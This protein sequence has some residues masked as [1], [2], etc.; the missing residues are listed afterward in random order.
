LRIYLLLLGLVLPLT[1]SAQ[2]D[3]GII[4]YGQEEAPRPARSQ[5][6]QK[7]KTQQKRSEPPPSIEAEAPERSAE[8]ELEEYGETPPHRSQDPGQE[9]S[10]AVGLQ[11]RGQ[12]EP[13][14]LARGDDPN[15]GLGIAA[16]GGVMLLDGARGHGVDPLLSGGVR[17]TWEFGRLTADE[18]LSEALFADVSWQYSTLRQGTLELSG[19]THYHHLT[20]A[21]AYAFALLPAGKLGAFLQLGGGVAYQLSSLRIGEAETVLGGMKPLLRY[22][23][24]FRGAVRLAEASA[25]RLEYRLELTRFRRG[26]MDDTFIGLSSGAVF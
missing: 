11:R 18:S 15:V 12:E 14:W 10:A 19:Q 17:A 24:G 8:I 20:L 5:R 4:P 23:G 1:V 6:R 7:V 22:G 25:W 21:P 13:Q 26:Y 3:D 9:E 2:Q 16:Q